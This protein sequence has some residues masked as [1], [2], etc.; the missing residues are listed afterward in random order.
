M[1]DVYG[2]ERNGWAEFFDRT[3]GDVYKLCQGSSRFDGRIVG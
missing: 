3:C 1:I 2:M